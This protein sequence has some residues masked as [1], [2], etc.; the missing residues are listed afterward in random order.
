VYNSV[1]VY[2]VAK[3]VNYYKTDTCFYFLECNLCRHEAVGLFL[4]PRPPAMFRL[5]LST[6]VVVSLLYIGLYCR[7]A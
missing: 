6:L 1:L 2:S 5:R 3:T 4:G 7:T